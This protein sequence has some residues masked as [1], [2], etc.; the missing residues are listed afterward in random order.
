M[1]DLCYRC[2]R[3]Y[4]GGSTLCANCHKIVK[5]ELAQRLSHGNEVKG[6]SCP[7]EFEDG[8]SKGSCKERDSGGGLRVVR[9]PEILR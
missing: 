1:N 4:T 9:K 7:P 5:A 8:P 2:F 6:T 3:V